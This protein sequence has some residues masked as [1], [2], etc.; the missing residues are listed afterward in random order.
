[1]P[2]EP[3][4][5]LVPEPE[6]PLEPDEPEDPFKPEVPEDPFK[7]E[8]PEDPFKPEVPEDPEDPL[9]PEDPS[10]GSVLIHFPEPVLGSITSGI[11]STAVDSSSK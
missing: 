9:E 7:P 6:E 10:G 1:M 3:E 8:V 2:L 4:L 5:P 11:F